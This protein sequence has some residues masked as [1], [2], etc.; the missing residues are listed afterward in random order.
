MPRDKLVG[1]AHDLCSGQ[2][3]IALEI[4][5]PAFWILRFSSLDFVI[6]TEYLFWNQDKEGCE[7]ETERD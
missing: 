3:N 6:V 7:K 2:E 4:E 5:T 1:R